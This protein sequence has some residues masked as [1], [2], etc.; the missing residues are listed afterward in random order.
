MSHDRTGRIDRRRFLQAGAVATAGATSLAPSAPAQQAAAPD[1]TAVL[2]RRK[3]GK[4]GL[5]VTLLEQ[6]A[7]RTDT[8]RVLR[9]AFAR[10]IRLFDTAKVY[11]TEPSFKKWFAQAPA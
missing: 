10:G 4:T 8:D 1:D 7:A 6:G 2:P 11:G 9:F 5:E 3:L